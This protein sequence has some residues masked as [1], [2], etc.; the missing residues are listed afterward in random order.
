MEFNL[1]SRKILET[2]MDECC[3]GKLIWLGQER[4]RILAFWWEGRKKTC[5]LCCSA[6]RPS[7]LNLLYHGCTSRWKRWTARNSIWR[8]HAGSQKEL[9][10]SSYIHRQRFMNPRLWFYWFSR[11]RATLDN[12]TGWSSHFHLALQHITTS[13]LLTKEIAARRLNGNHQF[14][15][16]PFIVEWV[17]PIGL[18][19]QLQKQLKWG[20]LFTS[21]SSSDNEIKTSTMLYTSVPCSSTVASLTTSAGVT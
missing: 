19:D 6:A 14:K 10:H 9:D 15:Y 4:N 11:F 12:V 17:A 13:R 5:S 18:R 2:V 20:C 16:Q 7:P 3:Y 1:S 21:Y 8:P